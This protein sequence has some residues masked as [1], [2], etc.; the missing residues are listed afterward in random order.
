MKTKILLITFILGSVW[1]YAQISVPVGGCPVN[2]LSTNPDN[3]DNSTDPAEL[4]KWDWRTE[5][6]TI[7]ELS[8]G[9]GTVG[10]PVTIRSPFFDI[11]N[12]PNTIDLVDPIKKNYRP[13]DGWELVIQHFGIPA[14]GVSHPYFILYN[15][16]S[17][18]LRCFVNLPNSGGLP[19][20][21]AEV[22][23]TFADG[24]NQTALLNQLGQETYAVNSFRKNATT[25]VPNKY[26]NSGVL[27]NYFWCWAD[28]VMLYDP[29][30]CGFENRLNLKVKLITKY[31]VNLDVN[32]TIT[33]VVNSTTSGSSTVENE[34][35]FTLIKTYLGLGN[36]ILTSANEGYEKGTK[37]KASANT[38]VMNNAGLFGK[39]KAKE[40]AKDLARLIF[41]APTINQVINTA[42]T[43]VSVIKKIKELNSPEKKK[44]VT[45]TTTTKFN[46]DLNISG[47][48][49][50][51]LPYG[52]FELGNPG[53]DQSTLADFRQ[54][55]YNNVLGVFNL[56]EQPELE[57]II[58]EP[59]T[60]HYLGNDGN[61]FNNDDVPRIP[62]VKQLR[63][64]KPLKYLLNPAAQV[65][66]K[67]L[68]AKI[69]FKNKENTFTPIS[70]PM[71]PGPMKVH[72][73]I[74]P[75]L[76]NDPNDKEDQILYDGYELELKD[77]N[78]TD[79]ENYNNAVFSTAY[80]DLGCVTSLGCFSYS[81]MV[82]PVVRVKVIVEPID[83]DP[84]TE[85]D[86]VIFVLT[87]PA[88]VTEINS[89]DKYVVGGT[90]HVPYPPG[91]PLSGGYVVPTV[92]LPTSANLSSL[93]Y[94]M[95]GSLY[96]TNIDV[97]RDFKA[98]NDIVI[99]PG[100]SL[101]PGTEH[102]IQAGRDVIIRNSPTYTV[103][104]PTFPDYNDY[105]LHVAAGHEIYVE[106]DAIINPTVDLYIDPSLVKSCTGAVSPSDPVAFCNSNDYETLTKG[107]GASIANYEEETPYFSVNAYPNPAR[108][109]VWLEING[110]PKKEIKIGI[111][112]ISGKVVKPTVINQVDDSGF[113]K[114]K[115]PMDG[116]ATGIYIVDIQ[117][118]QKRIKERIS[119]L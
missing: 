88:K 43:V 20:N 81:P 15:K 108:E 18:I 58:Y 46:T 25:A 37:F 75:W 102:F 44:T 54:T 112:D 111:V 33:N 96:L 7:Y 47:T 106:P 24:S 103:I 68:Q 55:A 59:N 118:G 80:V 86:Q 4:K 72:D 13:E 116:L 82:E 45:K 107:N 67:E 83:P 114:Y 104:G 1:G 52:D 14:Q 93:I 28:F 66:I 65:K 26:V 27:N 34:D 64:K 99:G 100:V 119:V 9:T 76:E 11:N 29:C 42:S 12:N 17:G 3:Y 48:I 95:P 41:E 19:N 39:Q 62:S 89:P 63:F 117:V 92:E 21:A 61:L 98:V 85:V 51:T 38:F 36:Q 50:L 56:E 16:Y 69:V 60:V 32:G 49:D 35:F 10:H 97:D 30:T 113:F 91:T 6:Y 22:K 94:G 109:D 2:T 57:Y 110:L 8:P 40:I 87:F 77:K 70:G 84:D 23:L 5:D 105:V 71:A 73:A 31:N 79:P 90:P 78:N 74:F 53:S 115:L 101:Q